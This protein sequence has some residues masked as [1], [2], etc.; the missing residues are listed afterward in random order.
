[1]SDENVKAFNRGVDA[2]NRRD[3]DALLTVLDPDVE[4]REVFNEMLGGQATV[5]RGHEGIR[6]LL[7]D[8]YGTFGEIDCRYPDVRDLDKQ[9]LGLGS[10]RARGGGS[11][12]EIESPLA[13]LTDFANGRAVRIRTFLDHSEALEAAGL[14]D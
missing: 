10:L 11:G 3:V 8:L 13:S 2:I 7:D 4:W 9:V 14:D 1:L 6:K 5:Y 12:A